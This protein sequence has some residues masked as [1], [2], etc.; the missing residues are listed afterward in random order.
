MIDEHAQAVLSLLDAAIALPVFDGK[1]PDGTDPNNG[2]VLCYFDD[3]D[4]EFDFEANAWRYRTTATIH[5][6]GGNA[7]AVRQTGGM[8]RSALIAV[9]PVIAGRSCWPITREDGQPPQ[10]DETTGGTVFDKIDVY[11]LESLPG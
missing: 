2:Y 1:V 8:V 10:R 11:V 6:V 5:S 7:Q 4:P 9:R 3:A